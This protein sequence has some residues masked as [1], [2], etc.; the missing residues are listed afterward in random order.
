MIL[1][2]HILKNVWSPSPPAAPP[3]LKATAPRRHSTLG[4]ILR[5]RLHCAWAAEMKRDPS[6][7][8]PLAG[9][10]V[11]APTV[12]TISSPE[13]SASKLSDTYEAKH[14]PP[15]RETFS[16]KSH[17]SL[18]PCV[19]TFPNNTSDRVCSEHQMKGFR[20]SSCLMTSASH[21]LWKGSSTQQSNT[22]EKVN[23]CYCVPNVRGKATRPFLVM[24]MTS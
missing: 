2:L 4:C 24:L 14:Y 3:S 6:A 23:S 1:R 7:A 12:L 5:S 22:G 19:W 13:D 16:V 8:Q 17:N 15:S 18:S 20:Q 10:G 9:L 21:V 11:N